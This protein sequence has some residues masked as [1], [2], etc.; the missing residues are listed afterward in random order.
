MEYKY[1]QV[2]DNCT[3][4]IQPCMIHFCVR[5]NILI[6]MMYHTY[7]FVKCTMIYDHICTQIWKNARLQC[8]QK[9]HQNCFNFCQIDDIFAKFLIT[10][11]IEHK[12]MNKVRL[13]LFG[14]PNGLI[15]YQCFNEILGYFLEISLFRYSTYFQN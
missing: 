15:K 4:I 6:K 5:S 11:S 7:L 13:G 1:G 2:I 9:N 12:N 3:L 14:G 10:P 8:Y